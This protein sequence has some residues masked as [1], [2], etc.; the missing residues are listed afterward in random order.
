MTRIDWRETALARTVN[1]RQRLLRQGIVLGSLVGGLWLLEILDAVLVRGALDGFGI[2]P[3]ALTSLPAVLVAPF[4]HA[5]F[6]H[7]LANTIPFV[8]LGW[9]VMWRRTSDLFVVFL[10]AALASGL[11]VWLFGGANTIHLGISGVIFGFLGFLLA[12]GYYERSGSAIAVALVAFL[13][14]GGILWGVLPLQQGV[15]WQ[16]HLF[17]FVGGVVT[18]YVMARQRATALATLGNPPPTSTPRRAP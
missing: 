4:L 13:L 9:M 15:S 10:A 17:G 14:Y 12:R 16:G 3:R 11:G 18:A 8:V 6:G 1:L 5:G 2:A 7:L